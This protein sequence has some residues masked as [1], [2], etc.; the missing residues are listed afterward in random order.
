MNKK[1]IEEWDRLADKYD[2]LKPINNETV[3][4]IICRTKEDLL[5]EFKFESSLDSRCRLYK[6]SI[7][8]LGT[9]G[10]F[11]L[12]GRSYLIQTLCINLIDYLESKGV[13]FRWN[14]PFSKGE[15]DII[16]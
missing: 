10:Y 1:G 6:D 4:P 7:N 5:S 14:E 11:T 15:A 13:L 8:G 3:M 16:V 9:S 12:Y 2:F